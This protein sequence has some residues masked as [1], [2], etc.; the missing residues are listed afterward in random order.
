[1]CPPKRINPKVR[2]REK[3]DP[4]AIPLWGS[5]YGRIP[6]DRS[7]LL[8]VILLSI[9]SAS[10]RQPITSEISLVLRGEDRKLDLCQFR[11]D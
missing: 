4:I 2:K 8:Q 10:R 9:E 11:L 7:S 3:G 5:R 1:M 6:L